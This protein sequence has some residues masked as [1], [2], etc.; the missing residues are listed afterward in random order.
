[1]TD[2]EENPIK[3]GGLISDSISL[4]REKIKIR[5][6]LK[7]GI[8]KLVLALINVFHLSHNPLNVINL[9]LLNNTRIFYHNKDKMLYNHET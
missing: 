2:F 9:G 5:L 1:M 4:S 7:N 8:E 6:T 3:V